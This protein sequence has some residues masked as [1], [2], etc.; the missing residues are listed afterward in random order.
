MEGFFSTINDVRGT[1]T[2]DIVQRIKAFYPDSEESQIR[3]WRVLVDDLKGAL[4]QHPLPPD[5]N[6]AI[7]Y[8]LPTDGMA[9]DLI[10]TGK[11]DNGKQHLFIIE[12]KQ[13]SDSFIEEASFT[14]Y[15]QEGKDLHPEI[16]V[17]RHLIS[18]RD[19][20]DIG[21]K[22]EIT[23]YVFVRNASS[24]GLQDIRDKHPSPGGRRVEVVND[25]AKIVSDVS[26]VLKH[27]SAE[28]VSDLKNAKFQPC[29]GIVDAMHSIVTKEEPFILTKEQSCAVDRI[30]D[31]LR[32]GKRVIRVTGAAGAGK[33]AILLN[34]YVTVLK[35][36]VKT[37]IIPIFVSGRQ[38]T[39]L[40]R[41]IYPQSEDTFTL[42]WTLDRTVTP[43]R[44]KKFMIFMDEAQ[45]NDEGVVTNMVTRGARLVLCYDEHQTINANNPIKELVNLESR[46]DFATI[47]L[48]ETVRYNGSVVAEKNISY[49]L[50][51]RTEFLADDKF[52]FRMFSNYDEFQDGVFSLVKDHPNSTVA[53]T[54]MLKTLPLSSR[55]RF[56][57]NWGSRTECEWIPYVRNRNYSSRFDGKLWVGSWWMPGLDVDYTAVIVGE[58]AVLTSNGLIANV[59]KVK[60]FAMIVSIAQAMHID[61]G[62][63]VNKSS[64][65]GSRGGIDYYT[66]YRNIISHLHKAGNEDVMKEFSLRC[67]EYIRN[68]YYIMMTR[69][70]KGCYV[71]F[72]CKR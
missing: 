19:Y 68:C 28:I 21:S 37:G 56:F 46:S 23:P 8:S 70:K 61:Q 43:A 5:V 17:C 15:R 34:L 12:S 71:Y 55:Q 40:Y 67:T 2:N 58:D 6:V 31:A 3:S 13:W 39:A 52:D 51:G 18:F 14:T 69:G 49:C 35:R 24:K 60:M 1:E 72:S 66:S 11:D 20:L 54:S 32:A 47:E 59:D 7:E 26:K 48:K 64:S 22:F 44:A 25:L 36:S 62:L 27:G 41:S 57:T 16:Q 10:L 63:V 29:K 38:N 30:R 53:V 45:H 50:S 33:T 4:S 9:A 65:Y 42:P